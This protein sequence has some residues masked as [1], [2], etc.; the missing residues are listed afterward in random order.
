MLKFAE[1]NNFTSWEEKY[2]IVKKKNLKD[3]GMISE[4]YE[5]KQAFC[6]Y[7]EVLIG[8]YVIS[9]LPRQLGNLLVLGKLLSF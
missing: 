3:K 7:N 6:L 9:I 1:I 4:L 8:F 5:E 2:C